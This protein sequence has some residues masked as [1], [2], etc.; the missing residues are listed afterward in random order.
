[1]CTAYSSM[2]ASLHLLIKFFIFS[3]ITKA[4]TKKGGRCDFCGSHEKL[5]FMAAI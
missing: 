4:T 2:S 1:M 5:Q 3:K